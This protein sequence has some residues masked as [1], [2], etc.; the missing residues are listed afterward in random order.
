MAPG[1]PLISA[2]RISMPSCRIW[3][4]RPVSRRPALS[5]PVVG[6]VAAGAQ[7]QLAAVV[8]ALADHPGDLGVAVAEHVVQQEHRALHRG[9]PFQQQQERH[10]QRVGLLGQA[11]RVRRPGVGQQRLGQPLPQ[12]G[13]AAH[14]RRAQMVDAQPGGHRGQ[15]RPRRVHAVP[16]GLGAVVAQERLLHHVLGVGH[17]ADHPVGDGEQQRAQ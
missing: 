13:L 8:L 1:C 9:Q 6:H 2:G 12:V 14:P 15:V 16:G 4:A 17:G 10:R 11:G 7:G 5:R 3:A